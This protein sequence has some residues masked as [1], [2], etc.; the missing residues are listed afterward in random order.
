MEA[1]E[2]RNDYREA[3]MLVTGDDQ[4]KQEQ[5]TIEMETFEDDLQNLLKV[6]ALHICY[7]CRLR[8]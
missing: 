2:V 8:S 7:I 5:V 4:M 6:I 3:A 1:I